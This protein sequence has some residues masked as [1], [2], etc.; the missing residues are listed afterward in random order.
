MDIGCYECGESS[1]VVGVFKTETEAEQA[2][3]DYEVGGG[4]GW[5]RPEWHGQHSLEVFKITV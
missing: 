2:N 1:A 3:K 5:G 4:T